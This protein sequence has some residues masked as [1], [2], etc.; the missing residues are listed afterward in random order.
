[1]AETEEAKALIAQGRYKEAGA[2]LDRTLI[3]LRDDDEAWYLRGVVFLKLKNY[4]GAQ[5][6]FERALILGRKSRY[7]QIKGMAHFE[8]FEMNEAAEAFRNA[9]AIE[10]EDATTNFFLAMSYLFLDDPRSDDHLK[11]ANGL[12]SKKTRA[13]LMNFFTLFIKDD[14]R[15]SAAQKSKIEERMKAIRG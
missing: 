6:C 4:D 2:A 14:P 10:P 5:E 11:R 8:L 15:I 13:L 7:Y 3:S 12:N 9:L 1:M